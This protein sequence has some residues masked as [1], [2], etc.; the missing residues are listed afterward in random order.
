MFSSIT[1]SQTP[2]SLPLPGPT[3]PLAQTSLSFASD[4]SYLHRSPIPL[5]FITYLFRSL[6]LRKPPP[7]PFSPLSTG[8]LEVTSPASGF[9]PRPRHFLSFPQESLTSSAVEPPWPFQLQHSRPYLLDSVQTSNLQLASVTEPPRR[10]HTVGRWSTKGTPA[11]FSSFG[12]C[13]APSSLPTYQK[14]L[15]LSPARLVRRCTYAGGLGF[16]ETRGGIDDLGAAAPSPPSGQCPGAQPV[17]P[18]VL[19]VPEAPTLHFTPSHSLPAPW[20]APGP[21]VGFTARQLLPCS[22]ST[23]RS[24]AAHVARLPPPPSRQGF[25]PAFPGS[26]WLSSIPPGEREQRPV[27]LPSDR[28]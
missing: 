2:S 14:S 4:R 18:H 22:N 9:L 20:E 26:L 25:V 7:R 17:V 21:I 8:C 5:G 15:P 13:P 19:S 27:S 10:V 12:P 1:A 28:S 11:H 24:E 23:A 16:M 6:P 3:L